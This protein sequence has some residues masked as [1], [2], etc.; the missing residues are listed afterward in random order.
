MWLRLTDAIT[1][2][3]I[4]LSHKQMIILLIRIDAYNVLDAHIR[5]LERTHQAGAILTPGEHV[6]CHDTIHREVVRFRLNATLL[7]LHVVCIGIVWESDYESVII[8]I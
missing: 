5:C 6:L 7:D 8:F 1:L 3:S 4:D 2:L